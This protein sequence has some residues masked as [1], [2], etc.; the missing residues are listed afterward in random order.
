MEKNF[1]VKAAMEPP[2]HGL[3]Y[4]FNEFLLPLPDVPAGGR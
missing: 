3:L 4:F 2:P 1:F